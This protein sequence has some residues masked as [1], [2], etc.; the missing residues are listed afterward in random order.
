MPNPNSEV[1]PTSISA[2][3]AGL[4]HRDELPKDNKIGVASLTLGIVGFGLIMVPYATPALG[5][6]GGCLGVVALAATRRND[7]PRRAAAFGLA[8]G[9]LAVGV[10]SFSTAEI[11]RGWGHYRSCNQRFDPNLDPSENSACQHGD[12]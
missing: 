6:A 8:V 11:M 3:H 5:L 9:I 7:K 2:L 12:R 4:T 10:G 1:A